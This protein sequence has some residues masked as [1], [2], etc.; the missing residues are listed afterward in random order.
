[1]THNKGSKKNY[2]RK[3]GY[4]PLEYFVHFLE[5]L[6]KNGDIMEIITYDDL[7]WGNDFDYASNY[8]QEY[9]RWKGE[10]KSGLR[11]RQKIYVLLQHDVDSRAERTMK[12][13]LKEEHLGIRSNVMI[14]TER[15]NRKKLKSD[16]VVSFTEYPVDYEYLR[17]LQENCGF[18]VG[19]H[20]N[21]YEKALFHMERA[22][23]IFEEDVA[24]LRCHF[25]ISYFSA[26]GGV[27][28]PVGYNNRNM[29]IPAS[30]R[31]DIRWVH[32]GCSPYFDGTYSDGGINSPRL[33]PR[34]RDLRDFV[35]RWKRGKRY[36]V[37]THP[38]YYNSPCKASPRLAG[39]PW[40][41][42]VLEVYDSVRPASAWDGVKLLAG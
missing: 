8:K 13:V 40:Y 1:M 20:C 42:E 31:N 38:Q 2:F 41:E 33:D 29:K 6:I 14:F 22:C 39:T 15:L 12:V 5:F 37:L 11:D 35:R 21:A 7:A 9:S 16:G 30:L 25:N 24:R 26:H 19:Y 23:K 27:P 32:N 10:M 34:K 18:V 3:G 36:R 28:G 17:N 4:F